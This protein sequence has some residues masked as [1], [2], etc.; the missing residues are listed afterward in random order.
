ME[1]KRVLVT[2]GTSGLGLAMAEALARSGAAVALTSR[3]AQRAAEAAAR[4]PGAA[5]IECDARDQASVARA[6]EDAWSRLGGIDMLVNNAG[7]GMRTVNPRFLS[8]PQPF[9]K[10]SPDGFRAVT[11]TNLTGYFL[12]AR[13]VTPRMLVAGHGRI[14]NISM[15][16]A[17]MTRAGFVP[18]G[19]S[20]A[21]AESLSRIMAADL[22]GSDVTV[23]MLLPGG[24]TR[25]GMIPPGGE[26]LPLLDPAIMGPPIV[27]LASAGADDVH[28][29][30]IVA[31]EFANWLQRR[32]AQASSLQELAEPEDVAD[33][34]LH[35]HASGQPGAGERVDVLGQF[36]DDGAGGGHPD[37]GRRVGGAG[38]LD[39]VRHAPRPEA[40]DERDIQ[41]GHAAGERAPREE[42][43]ALFRVQL[44]EPAGQLLECLAAFLGRGHRGFT[45]RIVGTVAFNAEVSADG[46]T[47]I[48]DRGEEDGRGYGHHGPG[49]PGRSWRR[50][51]RGI[52]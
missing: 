45:P 11:D 52:R 21:G 14:V 19:P 33:A 30:R 28:D 43:I 8:E 22:S 12:V 27:W 15:N 51:G 34:G 13:E 7:I 18:Y 50:T 20:R 32:Q 4:L 25:T 16:H 39:R 23:N 46:D 49:R 44:G 29:E 3:S 37:V 24:A 47:M 9:W 1:A 35:L 38:F 42:G 2:G 31:T 5:G 40:G 36:E 26:D 48:E 6:V 17:T 10:V 41:V